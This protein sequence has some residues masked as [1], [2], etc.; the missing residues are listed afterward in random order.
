MKKLL[1]LLIFL[2]I[3]VGLIITNPSR[4]THKEKI[5]EVWGHALQENVMGQQKGFGKIVSGVVG[6]VVSDLLI[7]RSLDGVAEY[8]NYFV[9]STMTVDGEVISFGALNYVYCGDSSQI[10]TLLEERLK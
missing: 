5:A 4:E 6:S 8:N 3:A 10:G 9:C 2:V 7:D 1:L